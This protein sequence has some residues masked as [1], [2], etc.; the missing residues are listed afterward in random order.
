MALLPITANRTST[1][2]STLRLLQQLNAD[3]IGLQRNYD[4][5]ST[6]RR[7]L[8]LADDPAA[9]GRAI[10][11]TRDIARSD[12]ILR[13]A[14]ATETYY[15]AADSALDSISSAMIL[16][17]ATAVEAAQTIVSPDERVS[18][19]TT[20]QEAINSVFSSAN[21]V[22]RD[23]QLLGG[24]LGDGQPYRRE[25]NEIVFTGDA[26]IGQTELGAGQRSSLNV[27]GNEALG[28]GSV[29]V[30]GGQ[31]GASVDRSTRLVDLRAGQGVR[32]G[33]LR[34]SGGGNFQDVDLRG[35]FTI[36]DVVD[37]LSAVEVEGRRLAASVLPDGIRIEYAD[38]LAGTLAIDDQV[39]GQTAEQLS[40]LNPAGT[41]PPPIE[42]DRL[43]PRIT[44]NTAIDDLAGGAGLD[45]TG[46][47]RIAQG[48]KTFDVNFD[49]A[50]TIGDVVIAINRSDADVHAELDQAGGRL[51]IRS[52]RFGVDYSIGENGGDAAANLRIRTAD[53]STALSSL[54]KQRGVRLNNGGDDVQ[55]IRPD[56][57]VLNLNLDD[58][59][60]I[61]DVITLIRDHP[62]N[63]DTARL[64]VD[65]NEFGNGLQLRAPPGADPLT[66]RSLGISNAATQLGWIAADQTEATGGIV[67]PVD[68][69]IGAD[70]APR[71][72]GGAFDTL[73]R[74]QRATGEGDLP[75]IERLQAKLD[76]DHDLAVRTRGRVGVWNR[77]LN[78][79][80]DT[81]EDRRIALESSRS[82]ELDADLA[83]VISEISQRQ[84]ALEA[85]MRLIGQTANFTVLNYL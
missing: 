63:Q 71:D 68:T 56:G 64:L 59:E 11:L 73:L 75:E 38:G 10:S 81:T 84:L 9:A 52:L 51:V 72:A 24:I 29:F 28:A 78:D 21:T 34:I 22:Y 55:I 1:P 74:L 82:E 79:L 37:V 76:D 66:V 20:I 77:N 65:L 69:I 26:A 30:R 19:E 41:Q 12:Q 31:I 70:F 40:I 43:T 53:G 42:G 7:V 44:T 36:G 14:E 54:N 3:Q 62:N 80:R 39:G 5:L 18:F 45:L 13:N 85:S 50:Q 15:N 23:H 6:G 61:D 4:Q 17:R 67:G 27:N 48:D 25:G 32:P 8:S 16:A 57:Q 46:G 35:A 33:I 47:I 83:S 58:A 60:T 2:L 49:N